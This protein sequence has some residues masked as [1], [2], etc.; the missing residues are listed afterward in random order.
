LDSNSRKTL[1]QNRDNQLKRCMAAAP[2]LIANGQ[3][4]QFARHAQELRCTQLEIGI[5]CSA[6]LCGWVYSEARTG[7]KKAGAG[8]A[9]AAAKTIPSPRLTA[10]RS[11][12]Y[13]WTLA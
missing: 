9:P 12:D 6:T 5:P 13:F 8:K 7:R 11:F 1:T 4:C 3:H 2:D 10:K